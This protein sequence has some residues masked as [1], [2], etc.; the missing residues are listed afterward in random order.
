LN[1]HD[2]LKGR[3]IYILVRWQHF[4]DVAVIHLVLHIFFTPTDL[5]LSV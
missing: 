5:E 2:V 4:F 3:D 1:Q